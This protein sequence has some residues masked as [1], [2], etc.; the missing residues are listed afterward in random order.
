MAKVIINYQKDVKS[1][2]A[3]VAAIKSIPG[4]DAIAIQ[5]DVSHSTDIDR[6]FTETKRLYGRIDIVV[7]NAG[8]FL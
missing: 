8:N 1:A 7:A 2:E 3:T 6:L 4:G 5:A